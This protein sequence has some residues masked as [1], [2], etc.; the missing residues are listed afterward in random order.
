MPIDRVCELIERTPLA[1]EVDQLFDPD[2]ERFRHP[3]Y[4]VD[5]ALSKLKRS[6]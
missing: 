1:E 2:Q 4:A 5:L 6:L 3:E